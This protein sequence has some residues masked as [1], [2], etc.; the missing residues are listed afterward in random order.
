MRETIEN[1]KKV[2]R[3]QLWNLA[4][5]MYIHVAK[6]NALLVNVLKVILEIY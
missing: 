6:F 1:K 5:S 2:Y 3:L 4:L